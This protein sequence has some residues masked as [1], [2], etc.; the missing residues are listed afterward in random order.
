MLDS[1]QRYKIAITYDGTSYGGW[2]IQPN[3]ISIQSSIEEIL[4]KILRQK[5]SI[6]G[7]SRT[8]AGVHALEQIAHFDTPFSLDKNKTLYALN[9]LLPPC[10]RILSLE[11]VPISFHARYD[12]TSKIYQYHLHL[13]PIPNPFTAK[14][15]Y[16]VFHR[17]DLSTLKR[18]AADLIGTHDFTS[19]ANEPTR[20]PVA[21][22]GGI[23]TLS[24]IDLI[25]EEEGICLEFE[26]NGFLYKMVRNIVGTF[27]EICQDKICLDDLP[28]ILKAKDRRKAGKAAPAHGLFLVKVKYEQDSAIK[29]A[30]HLEKRLS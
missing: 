13:S 6:I 3:C 23:R 18:A 14:Y 16:H 9:C 10:I 22:G 2:Q 8:D 11:S 4:Q 19:F 27:L 20:G 25:E 15:A 29:N 26:G 12:A 7:S 1:K 30:V 17:V 21:R 24:R 28:K 5:I